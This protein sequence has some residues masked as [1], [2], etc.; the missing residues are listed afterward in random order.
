[1]MIYHPKRQTYR[2]KF[3]VW[4]SLLDLPVHHSFGKK[5]YMV[6]ERGQLFL[7][8]IFTSWIFPKKLTTWVALKHDDLEKVKKFFWKPWGPNMK[9]IYLPPWVLKI[10]WYHAKIK[11]KVSKS[12]RIDGDRSN[13]FHVYF[14]LCLHWCSDYDWLS[15]VME[16]IISWLIRFSSWL[17]RVV[18]TTYDLVRSKWWWP[19]RENL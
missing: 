14:V 4:I 8:W 9:F 5:V 10:L 17:S 19:R 3:Q 16:F 15:R 18:A 2:S 13:Y 12:N 11:Q 7:V 1:M 6:T